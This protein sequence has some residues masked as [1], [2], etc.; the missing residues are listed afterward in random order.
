MTIHPTSIV[1]DGAILGDGVSI[2]PFCH[3]GPRVTLLRQPVPL[4]PPLGAPG[5]CHDG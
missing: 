1:E 4:G 2:G 3:I 5:S